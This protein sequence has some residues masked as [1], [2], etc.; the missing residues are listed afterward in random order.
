M[1][2]MNEECIQCNFVAPLKAFILMS[3]ILMTTNPSLENPPKDSSSIFKPQGFSPIL[4][5]IDA[6]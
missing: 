5:S 3:F 1:T 6:V 2:T 4:V